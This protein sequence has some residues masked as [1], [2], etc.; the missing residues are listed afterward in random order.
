MPVFTPEYLHKVTYQI[1][2]AKEA[3]EQEAETVANHVVKANL[4]G[5]DSH[6][7]IQ[8][9]EYVQRINPHFPYG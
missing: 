9:P 2:R 3:S 1:F 5:H 7:V 8:I 6:G 4:V